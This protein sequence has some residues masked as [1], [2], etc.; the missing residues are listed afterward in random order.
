MAPYAASYLDRFSDL[1]PEESVRG[2]EAYYACVDFVD[3]C[4]GELLNGL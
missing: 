2:R 3:D 4:I 1:T